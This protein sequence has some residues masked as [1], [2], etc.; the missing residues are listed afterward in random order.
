M[1]SASSLKTLAA[2]QLPNGGFVAR[3]GGDPRPDAAA[4]A[5]LGMRAAGEPA[6]GSIERARKALVEAQMHDGSVPI[7]PRHTLATW[8]TALAL[9]AWHGWPA[10]QDAAQHGLDFLGDLTVTTFKTEDK[11]NAIDS[12]LRGWSWIAGTTCWVE[13]T[14]MAVFAFER[15][16]R[17][18][19]RVN[20]GV[21]LLLDRQLPH[22][23]WNFGNTL[24]YGSELLPSE[25]YVG[26][27]LT[28]LAGHCE[29]AQVA[30]SIAF[31]EERL[32]KIRTPLALAW[33]VLGL[34]AWGR[35]PAFADQAIAECLDR[36]A[37][38]GAFD[39]THLALLLLAGH[40]R[41]G[42]VT[43]FAPAN[44]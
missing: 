16:G 35:R 19:E 36:Q 33:G 1:D 28:G 21:K 17:Q 32:V 2:R 11:V 18:L 3:D 31:I 39:T 14:A 12:S 37:Q 40:C 43:L 22:G 34:G 24:V 13:P 4:W 9:L 10:G 26:V 38:V 30:R 27:A 23:G 7:A 29:E 41:G 8:P 42:L 6:S 5:I 15:Y 44:S 20:E 25:E